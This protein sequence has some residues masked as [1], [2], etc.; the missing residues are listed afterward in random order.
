MSGLMLPQKSGQIDHLFVSPSLAAS[1][2]DC[3][4]GQIARVY[5]DNLSDHLSIIAA[6]YSGQDAA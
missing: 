2:T 1:L 5:G 3:T 4:T 6:F